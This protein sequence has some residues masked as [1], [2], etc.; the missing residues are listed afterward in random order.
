V[1]PLLPEVRAELVLQQRDL[2]FDLPPLGRASS[3]ILSVFGLVPRPKRR[4]CRIRKRATDASGFNRSEQHG[5]VFGV[6]RIGGAGL[7]NLG[8]PGLP[9]VF[10]KEVWD[11]WKF[12]ESISD[13]ARA[14]KKP[15]DSV[16]GVL[17]S[18]GGIAPPQRSRPR[19]SLSL[20]DWEEISRGLTSGDSLRAVALAKIPDRQV[21]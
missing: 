15:L 20:A 5:R 17:K 3:D 4:L 21:K 9:E 10:K 11:R 19:W 8:P 2:F 12:G 16:H 14:L 13:I 7:A 1:K 6:V 18:T